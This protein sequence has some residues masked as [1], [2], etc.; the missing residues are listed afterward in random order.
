MKSN[1]S[2]QNEETGVSETIIPSMHGSS[3]Q[4][5]IIQQ[6]QKKGNGLGTAGFV[7]S[8][9]GLIFCWVP[10]VNFILWILGLILS[11]VGVFRK[12][13]GLAIAG[14]CISFIDIIILISL[15]GLFAAAIAAS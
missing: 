10:V 1:V 8:L 11:A 3:Q 14:L 9:I 6:E 12:P 7:L 15:V 5:I 13:K 4:T 2:Q